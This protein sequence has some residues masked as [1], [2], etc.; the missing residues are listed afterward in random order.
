VIIDAAEAWKAEL[1]VIGSH[2][3]KG[4]QRFLLGSVA[5]SIARHA[6]CSVEII[7]DPM[8]N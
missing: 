8:K 5:E 4:L 2:G 7:R 6:A 1:I 3:R